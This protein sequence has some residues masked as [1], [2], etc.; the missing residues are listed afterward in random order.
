[1]NEEL[2]I[3]SEFSELGWPLSDE[4]RRLLRENLIQHGCRD[5][6]LVWANHDNVI[7]DGHNRYSICTDEEISY[8]VK[9][10][11]LETRQDCIDFIC[12]LQLSRRNSTDQHKMYLRGK[13]YNAEKLEAHRPGNNS[14]GPSELSRASDLA[15]E[16]GV[17]ARTLQKD[18]QFAD[19]VDELAKP[20]KDAVMTGDVK[21]SRAEVQQLADLPKA[22]QR[23]V[24]AAV[25]S[26]EAKNVKEAI[27]DSSPEKKKTVKDREGAEVPEHLHAIAESTWRADTVKLLNKLVEE[28]KKNALPPGGMWM[29]IEKVV[30]GLNQARNS[31]INSQ[32][33]AICPSCSGAKKGCG[34]CRK[35]GWVPRWRVDEMKIHNSTGA[36]NGRRA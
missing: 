13:R 27:G 29:D 16:V 30:G 32:F 21:A 9:A 18:G 5:P 36:S 17:S 26:G 1:M 11:R 31:I 33:Y 15:K 19:A 35:S 3:D 7:L 4:E 24:I 8:K 20:V 14:E 28:A 6:I 10:I 22:E 12:N 2:S 25:K 23:K 34:D